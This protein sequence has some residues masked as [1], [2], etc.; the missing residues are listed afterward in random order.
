MIGSF[1]YYYALRS[2]E[3]ESTY[4]RMPRPAAARRGA[5]VNPDEPSRR[6]FERSCED[7]YSRCIERCCADQ[8]KSPDNFRLPEKFEKNA[9]VAPDIKPI[10]HVCDLLMATVE[11]H[12]GRYIP[13]WWLT[14]SLWGLEDTAGLSSPAELSGLVREIHR[15]KFL[16]ILL[17]ARSYGRVAEEILSLVRFLEDQSGN[18]VWLLGTR[19]EEIF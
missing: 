1:I 17:G 13:P 14:G 6:D 19:R 16:E 3:F 12:G 5:G 7:I 10:N 4:L 2:N 15:S 8:W 18:N 11:I 9:G